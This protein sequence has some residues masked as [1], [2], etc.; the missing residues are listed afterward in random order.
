MRAVLVVALV[1]C[2]ESPPDPRE[3]VVYRLHEIGD[4]EL[5]DGMIRWVD[6][7]SVREAPLATM[8]ISNDDTP[9]LGETRAP[10][11]VDGGNVYMADIDGIMMATA[12]TAKRI[13]TEY[14]VQEMFV[15]DSGSLYW[16]HSG[17]LSWH[18]A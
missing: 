14:N 10:L 7:M 4:V 3:M 18:G 11:L 13:V 2:I 9:V 1:G 8:P 6:G 5:S 12:G 15:D 17:D 16:A